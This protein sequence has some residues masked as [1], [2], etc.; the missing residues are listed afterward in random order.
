M[1]NNWLKMMKDLTIR[2]HERRV[3]KAP[4]IPIDNE[5]D[6]PLSSKRIREELSKSSDIVFREF[7]LRTREE[8]PCVLGVVDG[9]ID[10]HLLDSYILRVLMVDLVCDPYF[11]EITL[12]NV[13]ESVMKLLAPANEIKKVRLMGEAIDA[14]LSG[15]AVLFFGETQDALVI[16]ARGW[17]SR[18]IEEPQTESTVRGPKEGFNETLRTSTSLLRRRIKH[19]S[20]RLVS[21]KIGDLTKTDVV[22]AY[23]ENIASPDVVSEVIKRLGRIKIDAIVSGDVLEE[24][25][26]D[27]PYSPLPQIYHTERPD[28][29]ASNLLEGRVAIIIDGTPTVL[30]VPITLNKFM[31]VNEDYYERAM[32]V[33]LIR[34]V[35]YLGAF[36]AIMAPSIYIAVTSFHQEILPT[37]LA[38]SVAAGREAV[39]FPA[40]VEALIMLLT[41]EILQEAGLRLPKPIGQTIGIVGALVIGDAAVKAN[42]VSPIMVIVIGLTAIASYAIPSYDLAISVRLT[43][44]PLMILAGTMGFFG[45]GIGVYVGLIHLLSIRSFG[46]PYMSPIAPLRIRAL[47]QDTFVRAPWWGMKRRPELIDTDDPTS[48]GKE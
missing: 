45:V 4:G 43:R 32:I 40:L 24:F 21:M 46:T 39:P 7:S 15:D 14:M 13:H 11:R 29:V 12:A 36:I 9:L 22:I 2:P 42:L 27:V 25:I 26:E 5:W 30:I 44:F 3:R 1:K 48:G 10:K 8:I 31:Q 17:Q 37:S 34:F 18:S 41:L 33:I 16:G 23:V 47:L 35:R 19:P 28:T 20:L 38:L 6:Q